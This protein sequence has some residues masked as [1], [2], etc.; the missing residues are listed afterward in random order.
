M[1]PGRSHSGASGNVLRRAL[2]KP[3]GLDVG[4]SPTHQLHVCLRVRPRILAGHDD[5]RAKPPAPIL[6]LELDLSV[7]LDAQSSTDLRREG[8]ATLLIDLNKNS[9]CAHV[10]DSIVTAS[11]CQSDDKGTGLGAGLRKA[12]D[13]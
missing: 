2:T 8:H 1:P 3:T 7:A 11:L 9:L 10:S 4:E 12:G 5:R 13:W 6:E